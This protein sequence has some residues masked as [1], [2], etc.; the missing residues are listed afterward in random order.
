MKLE[1]TTLKGDV[2]DPKTNRKA[3]S[4]EKKLDKLAKNSKILTQEFKNE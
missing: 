4:L 1:K 2:F 3:K